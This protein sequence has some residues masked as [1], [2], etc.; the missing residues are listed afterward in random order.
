MLHMGVNPE[1]HGWRP[2]SNYIPGSNYNSES[3]R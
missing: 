1:Q 2:E 3:V